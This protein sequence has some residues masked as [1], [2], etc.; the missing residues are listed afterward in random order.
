MKSG[1]EKMNFSP[2]NHFKMP[3]INQIGVFPMM[4]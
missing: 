1:S 3:Q 4:I 2:Q